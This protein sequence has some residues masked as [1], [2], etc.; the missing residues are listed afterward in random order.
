MVY[1]ETGKAPSDALFLRVPLI[2]S[3]QRNQFLSST[4]MLVFLKSW[5][6]VADESNISDSTNGFEK[7]SIEEGITAREFKEPSDEGVATEDN[8]STLRN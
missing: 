8:K 6:V 3:R 1:Q 7:V 5:A 2:K 4:K